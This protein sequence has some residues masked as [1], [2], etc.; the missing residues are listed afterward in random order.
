[1]ISG[2]S[3]APSRDNCYVAAHDAKTGA[4]LWRFYTAAGSNEPGGDTWA[5]APDA[6]RVGVHLGAAR[7][8]RPGEA[9]HLLGRRQ[10]HAQH[11]RQPSRRT[12]RRRFGF[13]APIDLYSNST[14]ALNPDTGKLA[15]YYQHLP[16]DDW[17]E[18]YPHER[19]LLRTR[20]AARIRSS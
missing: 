9:A 8:L 4:E 1:M 6:T 20:G 16:G 15:W 14:I 11:A 19:T 2:R 3:C 5:G 18:D 12:L 10:S 13:T 7:R 17:D